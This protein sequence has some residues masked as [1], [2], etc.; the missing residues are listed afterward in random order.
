MIRLLN[1]HFQSKFAMI[2]L[3]DGHAL[4][5]VSRLIHIRALEVSHVVG[6]ELKR[7]GKE[8][9]SERR[10]RLGDKDDI[11][12]LFDDLSIGWRSKGN[13]LSLPLPSPLRYWRSLSH[14]HRSWW[15]GRRPASP[16]RSRQ[17]AHASSHRLDSPLH[18][19][20][21]SPSISAPLPMQWDS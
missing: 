16:D 4:G 6:Q 15:R 7:N 17:W 3:F 8:N 14:R 9:G 19:H 5:Q 2:L 11:V 20:K 18:G 1:L 12:H 21:R 13:H 10:K